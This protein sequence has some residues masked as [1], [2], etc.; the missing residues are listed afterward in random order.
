M[1]ALGARAERVSGL[2]GGAALPVAVTGVSLLVAMFGFYWDVSLHIDRGRDN[3]P[4]GTPAHWF[5]IVG[6]AGMALA[7]VIAVVMGAE[8]RTATSVRLREGWH[9]PVGGLLLLLCGV[10]RVPARAVHEV[11]IEADFDKAHTALN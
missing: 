11:E 8:D 5:I 10:V 2:P 9:A 6:L 1:R 3:G 4:F 7:G